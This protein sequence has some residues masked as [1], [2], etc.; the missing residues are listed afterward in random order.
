MPRDL[1][2]LVPATQH[3]TDKAQRL[4]A[5]GYPAVESVLDEIM[6]WA[7][8][9]NWPVARVFLPFLARIGAPL[10][11][12]VRHVLQS[13]DE[14]WKQVVLGQVVGQS[15][16]LAHALAVDLQHL[17]HSPT[18]AERAEG[19]HTMAGALFEKYCGDYNA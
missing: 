2:T 7:E 4:V 6:E 17:M 16:A 11:P 9:A 10:A 19:L 8:D 12:R 3:E 5:L 18:A 14:Q 13:Q 15:A 1:S